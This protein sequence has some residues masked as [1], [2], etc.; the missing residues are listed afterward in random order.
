MSELDFLAIEVNF[1]VM[2]KRFQAWQLRSSWQVLKLRAKSGL[3]ECRDLYY[4]SAILRLFSSLSL[5]L[6]LAIRAQL[7]IYLYLVNSAGQ[8]L[9][10]RRS[11]R[12][13][14][15]TRLHALVRLVSM[16]LGYYGSAT[17]HHLGFEVRDSWRVVLGHE[18]QRTMGALLC[19]IR[20]YTALTT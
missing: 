12:Y 3:G 1:I 20:A 6:L 9:T 10:N 17:A 7:T 11:I 16:A 18:H 5:L 8:N 13:L 15:L 4:Y 19:P 14:P 2:G